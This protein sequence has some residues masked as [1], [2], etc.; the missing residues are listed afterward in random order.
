MTVER[1]I[2]THNTIN[3]WAV[4]DK[5]KELLEDEVVELLNDFEKRNHELY[6]DNAELKCTNRELYNENE[7][8]KKQMKKVYDYLMSYLDELK[9]EEISY[10]QIHEMD[11]MVNE[12]ESIII[13][14][15]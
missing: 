7:Q 15:K 6:L 8:L 9:A 11:S 10:D 12:I 14:K 4:L 13:L 2:K 1:F 5:G 3:W